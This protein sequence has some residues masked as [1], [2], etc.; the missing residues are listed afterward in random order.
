MTSDHRVA[1]SS[2]AGCKIALVNGPRG[3]MAR[4]TADE[5]TSACRASRMAGRIVDRDTA[6]SWSG[7][8]IATSNGTRSC[9]V[10]LAWIPARFPDNR[11]LVVSMTGPRLSVLGS[12]VNATLSRPKKLKRCR[13]GT[14]SARFLSSDRQTQTV[15]IRKISKN[16]VSGLE[17]R[18]PSGIERK[19]RVPFLW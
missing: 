3:S 13:L 2:P 18:E 5:S 11:S 17:P 6:A 15:K 9:S 12:P 7:A 4:F 8:T 1:G 19:S 10:C 16:R 14:C